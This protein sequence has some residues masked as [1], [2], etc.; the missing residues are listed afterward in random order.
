MSSGVVSAL[1]AESKAIS[2][3]FWASA[4]NPARHVAASSEITKRFIFISWF[5]CLCRLLRR[6]RLDVRSGGLGLLQD[7]LLHTPG[8]DFANDDLVRIAAIHHVDDLKAGR[9][10]AGPAE[11]ADDRA[12]QLHLV[13]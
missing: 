8:F 9:H 3:T 13:D 4:G 12:V 6:R 2:G 10:F 7:Q 1:V 11:L 5:W